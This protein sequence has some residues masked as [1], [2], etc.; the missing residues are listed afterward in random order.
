MYLQVKNLSKSYGG[1][2]VVSHINLELERGEILSLLGPSGCGKTTLLRMLVGLVSPDNG[3]IQVEDQV[4]YDGKKEMPIEERQMGMVFQDY[5]LWPHLTVAQNIAF[6]MH[7]QRYPRIQIKK[8]VNE[9]LELVN[10]GG[11]GHRF[12]YQLSGGQQQRVAMARALA[13]NPR[14]L[15]LDEPLSNLDT[16]LRESMRSEIVNLLRQLNVTTI[17]VTH[18]QNEAMAMSDRI[19]VLKEGECHQIGS[20]TDLYFNPVNPFVAKFMGSANLLPGNLISG[21]EGYTFYLKGYNEVRLRVANQESIRTSESGRV[22]SAEEC[23]LLIRPDDLQFFSAK[24]DPGHPNTLEARV[25][26]SSFVAGRW[27]TLLK[28]VDGPSP[29]L[30]AYSSIPTTSEQQ[31]WLGLPPETCRIVPANLPVEVLSVPDSW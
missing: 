10:L 22:N 8:R 26:E 28:L 23:L 12:P 29:T 3:W 31:C 7:L 13:T 4:L 17:N 14:I 5:A 18:D 19:M 11:L 24:L 25:V 15:L 20:P 27:R 6:G 9:L 21:V 16:A 30:L 1:K 2:R